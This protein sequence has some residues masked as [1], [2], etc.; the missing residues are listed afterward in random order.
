MRNIIEINATNECPHCGTE[1]EAVTDMDAMQLNN[2]LQAHY[3]ETL[4]DVANDY[5][6]TADGMTWSHGGNYSILDS[7]LLGGNGG[8]AREEKTKE[9]F[10]FDFY[11]AVDKTENACG[12]CARYA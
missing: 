10:K 9:T 4:E 2:W 5:E 7:D 12:Y 3:D 8:G 6:E 11:D 1:T